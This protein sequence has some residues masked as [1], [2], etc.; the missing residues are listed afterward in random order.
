QNPD[1]RMDLVPVFAHDGGTPSLHGNDPSSQSVFIKKG[2]G[3]EK[4]T[5]ILAV[6]NYCAAPFGTVEYMVYRYGEEGRHYELNDDGAPELTELGQKEVSNGYL[7]ISGRN[8]AIAES[9]YPDYVESFTA[10]FNEAAQYTEENP[11]EGIRIQRP[12]AYVSVEQPTED[13]ITA[14]LRG[15]R[16]VS[17]LSE[18]VAPWRRDGG[19][20]ARELYDA[21]L[22]ELGR[23]GPDAS[24][25]RCGARGCPRYC[26]SASGGRTHPA[27]QPEDEAP[28]CR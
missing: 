2:L 11:F 10:W 16:E 12:S 21:V 8:N 19:D 26:S 13:K 25:A 14:I 23:A 3:E 6:L 24:A 20:A 15:R 4:V 27:G 18:V 7:F 1:F 28:S 22:A 17:E 9:E 5:E